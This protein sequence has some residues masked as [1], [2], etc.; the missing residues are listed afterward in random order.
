MVR[1]DGFR[2][3]AVASWQ[4][5]LPGKEG[6]EKDTLIAPGTTNVKRRGAIHQILLPT[7][8]SFEG[9]DFDAFEKGCGWRFPPTL[10][11]QRRA[12]LR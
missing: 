12:L 2:L 11:T 3:A 6:V 1:A 7:A 10:P 9:F 8:L 5:F 4:A